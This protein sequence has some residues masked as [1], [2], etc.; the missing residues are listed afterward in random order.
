MK[1]L[2]GPKLSRLS[3]RLK[4]LNYDAYCFKGSESAFLPR[5]VSEGRAALASKGSL[6][7]LGSNAAVFKIEPKGIKNQL[8]SLKRSQ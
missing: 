5:T 8:K 3:R 7:R 6:C 1:F 2:L 4:I